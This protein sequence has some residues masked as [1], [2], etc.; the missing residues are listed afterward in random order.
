MSLHG[1]WR[2]RASAPQAADCRG[3]A[4]TA[5]AGGPVADSSAG[6]VAAILMISQAH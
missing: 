2:S 4:G 3:A 1:S 6:F 5:S